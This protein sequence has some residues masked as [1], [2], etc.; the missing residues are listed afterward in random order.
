MGGSVDGQ[1]IVGALG[2]LAV[3]IQ[4][5]FFDWDDSGLPYNEPPWEQCSPNLIQLGNYFLSFGGQDLGCEQ[6]RPVRQGSTISEHSWGAAR[7]LRY[8]PPWLDGT[9]PPPWPGGRT[10]A[11]EFIDWVI[12]YSVELHICRINDYVG[13][14]I[15]TAGRTA[16][17]L[18]AYTLWWKPQGGSGA[19]GDSWARYFHFVTTR[20]GWAD[21]TPIAQRGIPLFGETAQ[22][23]PEPEDDDMKRYIAKLD[24]NPNH[25]RRGDGLH[26]EVLR[27]NEAALLM[28]RLDG[29]T[30]GRSVEYY[31]PI[32][33]AL[34]TSWWGP[35]GVPTLTETQLDL[36][37]GY[38]AWESAKDEG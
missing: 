28:G 3:T 17:I 36:D 37:V 21:A 16:N 29:D 1:P 11:L 6:D 15:W 19:M 23:E 27:P 4:R 13:D 14:R 18:D 33:G 7:D 32:T 26:A 9:N 38:L 22:P 8:G 30:A 25:V 34:I 20:D 5:S 35:T 12:A 10:Q 24:T 2:S 31:H